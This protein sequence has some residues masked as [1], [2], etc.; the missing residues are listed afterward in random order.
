MTPCI[1]KREEVIERSATLP[2]FP[3]VIADI[4]ATLDDPDGSLRVL[5]H[6]VEH[7]PVIA[8][9]VISAANMAAAGRGSVVSDLYTATSLIGMSRVRKITLVSS[10][11]AFLDS[12]GHNSP[13]ATFWAHCMSV[14]LCCHELT[15]HLGDSGVSADTALIAGL[16]HDIG[17][18][19]LYSFQADAY[20]ACL[21]DALAQGVADEVMERRYFGA[22]H[23][24]L[25]AWLAA[26][27]GLPVDIAAAIEG[28]CEPDPKASSPLVAL[29]HVGEVLSNALGLAGPDESRVATL[30]AAACRRLG[31]VFDDTVR[32]LLGRIDARSRQANEIFSTRL[33]TVA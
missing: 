17:Q 19:W 18:L 30:S 23:A 16:L 29:V 21:S 9:R 33:S 32:P 3:R 10:V 28:H 1:L 20:R 26:H 27:W 13:P 8:A 25:G 14:G 15:L 2:S 6:C 4:L 5:A 31:L 11:G 12:L 24:T 7:D 22:D